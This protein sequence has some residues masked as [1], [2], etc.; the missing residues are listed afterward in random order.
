MGR[1]RWTLVTVLTVAG[2]VA[3]LAAGTAI[4]ATASAAVATTN[5]CTSAAHPRIAG[6]MSRGIAAVLANRRGS[7]VGLAA[8][9]PADGLTCAFHQWRYF[10]SASVVKVT[11]LSSL[12]LK[13]GAPGHL[14]SKQRSLA[15]QMITQ[16][17]N[18][19]ATALWDEVGMRSLQHF[20]DEAGMRN[21]ILNGRAWGLTQIT[22]HDE[23]MLLNLLTTP[24]S[25]LNNRSRDYV[26]QLMS[27]VT[28]S[29]R[30][31]VSA[32]APASV[33]VHI[34]NGWLPYPGS[35][36]WRINSIGAFTGTGITYQIVVLTGP[37]AGSGQSE[38]YGIT[39]TENV[40]AVI[41]RGLAG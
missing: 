4:P 30:W 23:L 1:K 5:I 15:N 6:R 18:S 31:G 40:A 24:G 22:A 12:L 33:T 41:N 34:K 2:C 14:T 16:S 25:V 11:I 3:A 36:D 20:L 28:P 19:A 21:T 26:L 13:E 27:E 17:S 9:A 38:G 7:V 39:T 8:S 29:E 37:P 35:D 32:G 10:Y